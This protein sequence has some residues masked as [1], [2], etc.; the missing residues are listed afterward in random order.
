MDYYR[1]HGVLVKIIR[2][3]NTYGPNM[4]TDDGRVISNFVVQALLDKDITIYGDGKQTRS[5]Q[6]IDD[7][8][9]GMI[10]MMATED[11]FTGPVNIGNPCEFS[12]FELAQKILELTC[13]HSN[14]IFEPL[15]HD[16]PRQRRPDIT[17]AREK[18]DWEPH[19]HL[20]EGLMKVIDYFKSVLAK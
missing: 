13:S 14:I 16:D 20:E 15:P 5:F 1:Q 19:I 6:Y 4:L 7:L 2:I 17:L 18:L 3:F 10:R 9:E 8:V 11:H 12:I